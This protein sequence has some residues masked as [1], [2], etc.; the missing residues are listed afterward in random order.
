[1]S[2]EIINEAQV[3]QA[4]DNWV[5][6]LHMMG[7]QITIWITIIAAVVLILAGHT[8]TQWDILLIGGP[9]LAYQIIKGKGLPTD[10]K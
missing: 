4:K 8:F 5:D 2:E 10:A 1:M 7:R 6:D 9:N 3:G